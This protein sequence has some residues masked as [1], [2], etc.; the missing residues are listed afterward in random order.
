V[1][2]ELK[3]HSQTTGVNGP[4]SCLAERQASWDADIVWMHVH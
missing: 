3:A 1:G 4:G 2:L